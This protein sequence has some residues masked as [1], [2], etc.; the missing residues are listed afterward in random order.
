[1]ETLVHKSGVIVCNFLT[2]IS[3]SLSYVSRIADVEYIFKISLQ[4]SQEASSQDY[5]RAKA[6]LVLQPPQSHFLLT[7]AHRHV[8]SKFV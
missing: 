3:I 2:D 7:E 1:M 5:F 4:H 6:L 8:I